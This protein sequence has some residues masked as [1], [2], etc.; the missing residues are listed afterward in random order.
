M[1]GLVSEKYEFRK[2]PGN[3]WLKLK[4]FEKITP[5]SSSSSSMHKNTAPLSP[6]PNFQLFSFSFRVA[7]Q[8]RRSGNVGPWFH[9]MAKSQLLLQGE[10]IGPQW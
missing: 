4:R 3:K 6:I 2:K 7:C 1:K 5:D 8:K 9:R 10:P